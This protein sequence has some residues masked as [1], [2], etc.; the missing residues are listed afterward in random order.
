MSS[1]L[2]TPAFWALSSALYFILAAG[3]ALSLHE[4]LVTLNRKGPTWVLGLL[5]ASIFMRGAW[6]IS[7]VTSD[8]DLIFFKI[9]SRLSN[10]L[11]LSAIS[12]LVFRWYKS[13]MIPGAKMSKQK[14]VPRFF[15][16]LNVIFYVAILATTRPDGDGT[17]D[18]DGDDDHNTVDDVYRIN[19]MLL[20]L[21]F[22]AVSGLTIIYGRRLK[23][24][25]STSTNAEVIAIALPKIRRVSWSLFWCFLIRAICYSYTPLSGR[26]TTRY[27][28]LDTFMYPMCFY[29]VAELIPAGVIA[30]SM[31]SDRDDRGLKQVVRN[32]NINCCNREERETSTAGMK[33]RES[34]QV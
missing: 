28:A 17:S 12:V 29:H 31:L 34:S 26:R 24:V 23:K 10:L 27:E 3:L 25:I 2:D 5:F 30:W 32:L 22:V 21:V 8:D 15:I 33:M 9:I 1:Q 14:Y 6:M 7:K 4:N 18:D 20:G 11:Q 16:A 13:L 19:Q